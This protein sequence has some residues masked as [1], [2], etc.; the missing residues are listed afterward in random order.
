M[1]KSYPAG[2]TCFL[3]FDSLI[4]IA[5][6][7]FIFFCTRWGGGLSPDSTHYIAAA[8]SLLKGHG[9]MGPPEWGQSTP[10]TLYGPLFPILLALVGSFG[11]DPLVAAKFLNTGLFGSNICLAGFMVF[12]AT[13]SVRAALVSSWMIM[14]SFVM[15]GLHAMANSE[16]AFIF[17]TGFGFYC[18]NAHLEDERNISILMTAA[19]S[20][21]LAFLTRYAGMA[22]VAA[23]IVSF[24]LLSQKPLGERFRRA[25]LMLIVGCLP[26]ILWFLRNKSVVGSPLGTGAA[27]SF[28]PYNL[29]SN[30]RQLIAYPSIWLLPKSVPPVFRA[31]CLLA[32]LFVF[33]AGSAALFKMKANLSCY[34]PEAVKRLRKLA[35]SLWVF[36]G[37]HVGVYLATNAFLGKEAIDDRALSCVHMMVIILAASAGSYVWSSAG[38][39]SF[40]R[41]GLISAALFFGIT[42]LG[43]GMQWGHSTW[44]KGLGYASPAWSQ[45]ET[46]R[47]I[48]GLPAGVP[49]YSNGM[50]AVYILTGRPS[51][52][53]PAKEHY[54]KIHVSDPAGRA[55]TNYESELEKMKKVL[56]EQDG[57]LA[58]FKNIGWRWY[59]P[60]E[61]ELAER[62]SLFPVETLSDGVLYKV[63]K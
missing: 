26:M 13:R 62:L 56:Q 40:L 16:P 44:D 20:L 47:K 41:V 17:F 37:M 2:K 57:I 55:M 12:Y 4:A 45:S 54:M 36:I 49:V 53:I 3:T 51:S 14:T 1:M 42:Y 38:K 23:G 29:P 25:G 32:G 30:F 31:G 46:L 50:D 10:F 11:M 34:P 8:R 28:Q 24:V 27:F 60:T 63:K 5:G 39:K 61:A 18:L 21:A 22:A 58:Y 6:M 19:S 59:Y 7:G 43:R 35:V 33:G 48:A 9:L 52:P 15:L